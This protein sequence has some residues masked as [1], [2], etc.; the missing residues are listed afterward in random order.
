MSSTSI[1]QTLSR[2]ELRIFGLILCAGFFV[3]GMIPAIYRGTR[4][5]MLWLALSLAFALSGLLVPSLL[6]PVYKIWMVLGN[7]LGWVNTRIL[8]G[9]IFYLIV[10]PVRFV[11][12]VFGNDPMNRKFDPEVATYRIP[13]NPR[14]P[15]HMRHQF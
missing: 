14:D 7:I 5:G 15:A 8:L 10:T 1:S 6:R 9:L 11:M 4:P 12:S 3:I 13:R 2:K